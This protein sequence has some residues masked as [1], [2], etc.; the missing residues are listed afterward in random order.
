MNKP[1]V[2]DSTTE[3]EIITVIDLAP[4]VIGIAYLS[5]AQV[6]LLVMIGLRV[7]LPEYSGGWL[8]FGF[9]M[10]FVVK[11]IGQFARGRK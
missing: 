11:A 2:S 6:I 8:L 7:L 9:A 5:T 3:A 1:T 10:Y 4:F